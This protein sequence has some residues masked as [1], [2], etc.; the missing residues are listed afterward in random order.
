MSERQNKPFVGGVVLGVAAALLLVVAVREATPPALAQS[1][2]T[3][4]VGNMAMVSGMSQQNQA[5]M[6]FILSLDDRGYK[7]LTAYRC[8]NGRDLKLIDSRNITWD[9]QI[10]GAF[11]PAQRPSVPEIKKQVEEAIKKM[12]QALK[13]TDSK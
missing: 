9:I 10:P 3:A 4:A 6:V 12:E 2:A 5:D 1:P 8:E 13:G 11:N 7:H